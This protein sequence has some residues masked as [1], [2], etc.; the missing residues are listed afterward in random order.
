MSVKSV[1]AGDNVAVQRVARKQVKVYEESGVRMLPRLQK[2]AGNLLE[3]FISSRLFTLFLATL[4]MTDLPGFG[5]GI[6]F[7]TDAV[8]RGTL[9]SLRW[10]QDHPT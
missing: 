3:W 8:A 5:F 1:K 9:N 6:P 2:R 4:H 7:W 10:T